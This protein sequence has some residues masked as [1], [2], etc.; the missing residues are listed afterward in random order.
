MGRA[1]GA[2][3]AGF[4]L[5]TVLWLGFSVVLQGVY[6]EVVVP[7]QRLTHTG[8]LIAFILYSV[9]ISAVSGWVCAAI[10]GASPMKTVWVLAILL[11][12]VG[13]GVE[14]S[15][16][17]LTPAWYHIVF[18]LLL[19]PATLFGGALKSGGARATA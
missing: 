16:W 3:V 9:V 15:A 14:A 18:L 12:F 6:P 2:V 17:E 5:W 4:V 1:I 8:V 7:G 19:V 11:L 10:R 13:I